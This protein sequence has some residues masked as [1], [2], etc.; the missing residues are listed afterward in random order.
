MGRIIDCLVKGGMDEAFYANA[1]SFSV[2]SILVIGLRLLYSVANIKIDTSLVFNSSQAAVKTIIGSSLEALS[3]YD[4]TYL[5]S[6]IVNDTRT[7][8]SFILNNV[9]ESIFG[10]LQVILLLVIIG[11]RSTLFFAIGI[12]I[13]P[14]CIGVFLVFRKNL[15]KNANEAQEVAA[16]YS[17][18]NQKQC[19][20]YLF[21]KLNGIFEVSK[22]FVENY[23]K[24]ALKG[25]L[26]YRKLSSEMD[27]LTSLTQTI[28]VIVLVFTGSK[29]VLR[30]ELTIGSLTAINAYFASMIGI[31]AGLFIALRSYSEAKVSLIRMNEII[32][33]PKENSGMVKQKSIETIRLKDIKLKLPGKDAYEVNAVFKKGNLYCLCGKNGVGKSTLV[34]AIMGGISNYSGKIEVNGHDL[35]EIDIAN[36]RK[37]HISYMPQVPVLFFENYNDIMTMGNLI[38]NMDESSAIAK[39]LLGVCDLEAFMFERLNEKKGNVEEK[40]SGGEKQKIAVSCACSRNSEILILDEPMSSLDEKSKSKVA[41]LISEKAKDKIVICISHDIDQLQKYANEVIIIN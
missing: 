4:A 28:A 24:K 29:M 15:A 7:I 27:A 10:I 39:D 16:R 3:K 17:S 37:T 25:F 2:C 14:I 5:S 9:I 22:A 1:M 33:E 34:K 20:N 8:I 30:K 11:S 31:I 35:K 19:A 6:R 38:E 32:R 40:F 12:M 18:S 36:Y 21:I 23:F 13:I 41:K 26:K